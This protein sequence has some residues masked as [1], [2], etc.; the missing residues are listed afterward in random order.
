[1]STADSPNAMGGTIP[2]R[3][4]AFEPPPANIRVTGIPACCSAVTRP[5]YGSITRAASDRAQIFISERESP[6]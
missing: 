5:G 3:N 6:A 1:M 2:G 4:F